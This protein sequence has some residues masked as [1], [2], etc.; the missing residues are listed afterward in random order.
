M[1]IEYPEKAE[2][3]A[4]GYQDIEV[5]DTYIGGQVR[6]YGN[7]SFSRIYQAGHLVPAYQP[8]TAYRVF[9]RLIKGTTIS[10]GEVGIEDYSST[11]SRFTT[12]K[13][14]PPKPPKPTCFVRAIDTCDQEPWLL[15]AN[16]EA[17]IFNGVVY[18][19]T[20]DYPKLDPLPAYPPVSSEDGQPEEEPT[21][22]MP[23]SGGDVNLPSVG[24]LLMV[25]VFCA[26]MT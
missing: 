2:F 25:I 23:R 10:K 6:Q 5:N 9:E 8:E 16:K 17:I 21:R 22:I 20:D 15:F 7:F 4:A 13:L 14:T 11:G 26:W 18:N 19:S 24:A 3:R 12:T 1:A